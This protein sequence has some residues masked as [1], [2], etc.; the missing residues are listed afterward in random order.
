MER[1]A[2]DPARVVEANRAFDELM[3]ADLAAMNGSRVGEL[4][5]RLESVLCAYVAAYLDLRGPQECA[6][7]GD[8]NDGY[9][10]LP[11]TRRP[12]DATPPGAEGEE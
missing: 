11:T 5:E 7:M 3:E 9:V 4:E 10:L 6:F 2:H 12:P 1:A 8:L